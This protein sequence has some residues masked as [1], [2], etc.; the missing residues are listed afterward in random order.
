MRFELVT[1]ARILVGDGA[2]AELPAVVRQ[3]VGISDGP[4][5]VVSVVGSGRARTAGLRAALAADGIEGPVLQA[6]GEPTVE[7]ARGAA[8]LLREAR[9]DVVV[10]IG[11]GSVIDTAKAVAALAANPGDVLDYL[12]VIGRGRPLTAP[13]LPVV[14]VPTTAGSG[15]EV[16]RNAV[17]ASPE[18]RVKVS[19]RSATMVPRVALV[20]PWLTRGLP[21]AVTA[22]TGLDALT[23]V[24]E[25]FVSPLGN[26]ATD[27]LAREGIS[28]AARSLRRAY[29]V[30]DDEARRDMAI[31]SLF[32]GLALANAKLGAVHGLAGVIG[33]MVEGPHGAVCARLLP[34]V[35]EANLVALRDREPGSP[36]LGRYDEVARLVTGRPDATAPAGAA[37]VR[38]LCEVLAVPRLGAYG[39]TTGDLAAVAAGAAR[40]SSTAG[41][42][43]VLTHDELVGVL[44][45]AL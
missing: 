33:G 20:D 18:H 7:D 19:L 27:A 9:P 32:G 6:A 44:E 17:L 16:T 43:V 31:A 34:L 29:E 21:P 36:A 38:D 8:A 41:N 12:E 42:P 1:P 26:P 45:R 3:A 11:G 2:A 24:I 37:W 15:S 10:A 28:R 30:G 5:R 13:S 25:P 14:A 39:L 35:I 22:A 23:Q 40:A 4:V